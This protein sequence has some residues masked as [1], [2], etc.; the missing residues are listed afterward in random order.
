MEL[1]VLFGQ[2]CFCSAGSEAHCDILRHT[3]T[4][5]ILLELVDTGTDCAFPW[6]SQIKS[7]Y[8]HNSPAITLL[9]SSV[10]REIRVAPDVSLIE[11]LFWGVCYFVSVTKTKKKSK[12]FGAMYCEMDRSKVG[13]AVVNQPWPPNEAQRS[14]LPGPG[15][16]L[17]CRE[18]QVNRC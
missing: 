15:R 2:I 12:S 4:S 13:T 14:M 18:N 16:N 9:F 7:Y 17:F 1:L 11:R 3:A 10:S 6:R 8:I 5:G